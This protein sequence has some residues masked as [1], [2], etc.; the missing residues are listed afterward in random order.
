MQKGDE[1][2]LLE[3]ML[4]CFREKQLL[5][6]RGKQRTDSTHIV[7]SVR[8]LSRL[9]SVAETLRATLNKIAKTHH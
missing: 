3:K 2:I 4:D 9:E 7:A 1:S 5:K 6:A 8:Y